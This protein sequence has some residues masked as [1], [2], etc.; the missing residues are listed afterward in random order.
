MEP[1]EHDFG[2]VPVGLDSPAQLFVVTNIGTAD[3]NIEN[4]FL[5]GADPAHFG[6]T[7]DGCSGQSLAPSATCQFEAV[8][9]PLSTGAKTASLDIPSNDP[10]TPVLGVPVQGFGTPD[11]DPIPDLKAN[12]IDDFLMVTP[13]TP[14]HVTVSLDAAGHTGQPAEWWIG[15]VYT[16]GSFS[17]LYP[18][19]FGALPIMDIPQTTLMNIPLP[20]GLLFFFFVL[21]DNP[22]G[23][24]EISWIDYV[25]VAVTEEANAADMDLSRARDTLV[26][27][28]G[29]TVR[30]WQHAHGSAPG[31]K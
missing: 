20:P 30:A 22:N 31:K 17:N 26:G 2:Q 12:G 18:I 6:L 19:Y 21:D 1:V 23:V 13:Q 8:F 16:Y 9:S 24:F 14:V 10:D 27:N 11:G 5:P 29:E 7:A 25:V 3:L 15:L 28:L 4:I